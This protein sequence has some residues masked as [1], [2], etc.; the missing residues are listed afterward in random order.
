MLALTRKIDQRIQIGQDIYITILQV[1]GKQVRVGIEAPKQV[2]V[3]RAELAD[4]DGADPLL[5][6]AEL[7]ARA[8]GSANKSK[9]TATKRRSVRGTHSAT[10]P[11]ERAF[12]FGCQPL[13]EKI[14][15][16]RATRTAPVAVA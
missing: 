16:R 3:K 4:E 5:S 13:A 8:A 11:G 7:I 6:V 12:S 14:H 10:N 9:P 2:R 15:A 1:R